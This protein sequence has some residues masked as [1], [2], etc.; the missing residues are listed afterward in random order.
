MAIKIKT[1]KSEKRAEKLFD[2]MIFNKTGIKIKRKTALVR[3]PSS[4]FGRPRAREIK[5]ILGKK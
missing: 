3:L 1:T 2:K 4:L 5:Y